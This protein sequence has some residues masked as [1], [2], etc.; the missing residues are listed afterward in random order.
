MG[1][2]F[3]A[4]RNELVDFER[5]R[6]RLCNVFADQGFDGPKIISTLHIDIYL[7]RKLHVPVY[8]LFYRDPHNFAL[9]TGT[10]LY[11]G[12]SS[13]AAAETLF[14]HFSFDSP[15]WDEFSGDFCA[16]VARDGVIRIFID[17]LGIY[18]VYRD[19]PGAV[20]STSFLAVLET[21]ERPSINSQAVYEYVFQGATYGDKT[22]IEQVD[23]VN[24]AG[25]YELDRKLLF[26]AWPECLSP[27]F[28]Q[29]SFEAHVQ[30]SLANLRRAFQPIKSCFGNKVSTALTGGY[31]SRLALA[32]LWE[33]GVRPKKVHVYGSE[34]DPDVKIA[35]QIADRDSFALIHV[36]KARLAVV[37][38]HTFPEV[39]AR[40]FRSFDGC[41]SDGILDN[42]ADLH[43]RL[44][45]CTEGELHLNAGGG[46]IFRNFFNL[47]DS[48]FSIQQFLWSFYNR[49]DPRACTGLFSERAYH[50]ALGEKIRAALG[51]NRSVL[52]REEIELLYVIFRCR[53]WMGKNNSINNRFGW[54]LTPFINYKVV[55]DAVSIPLA[56]KNHGR[57][58]AT[59][60]Q[61]VNQ[62]LAQR[63]SAYGHSFAE[64]PPLSRILSDYATILRP[65]FVRR[66]TYRIRNRWDRWSQTRP[67]YL[68]DKYLHAVIER[69][70]PY[71]SAFF[72]ADKLIEP[73]AFNRCCT[74]EYLFERYNVGNG[75]RLT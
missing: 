30:K 10:A 20:F 29:A 11:R 72:Y 75:R 21:I 13:V 33:Q 71:M 24:C 18:K 70:F 43:T 4:R 65:P 28:K 8:Q 25:A 56:Y 35:R 5:T 22:V 27:R 62:A 38:G 6:E 67:Y 32:L 44:D 7:Y 63:P 55:K 23:V 14:Q 51:H 61:T 19:H 49:Y 31:D 26:R 73:R 15:D 17:P 2:F 58:E 50:A 66:Y 64:E 3:L 53:Y 69:N 54:T 59:L 9:F 41:P 42:G 57:L 37:S 68:S 52:E 60:I 40:N 46:E 1:G 47:R 34:H 48:Q 74:L 45:R 39:V 12:R 36:N 16:L